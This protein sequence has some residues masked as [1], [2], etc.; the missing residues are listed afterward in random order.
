MEKLLK[1]KANLL[2]KKK[3]FNKKERHNLE[4]TMTC[5]HI[6]AKSLKDEENY[7][8]NKIQL[9]LQK[10]KIRGFKIKGTPWEE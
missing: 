3:S 9:R 7:E 2:K 1:K 8:L 5:H 4:W 6:K 10:K